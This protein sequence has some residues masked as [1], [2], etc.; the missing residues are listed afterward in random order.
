M[1]RKLTLDEVQKRVLAVN[2]NVILLTD[3]YVDNRTNMKCKCK[4]C[5]YIWFARF[6]NLT[7]K[8]SPR[9]CPQCGGTKKLTIQ[10]VEERI[11]KSNPYVELLSKSYVNSD[12]K[13]KVK[14][15][16][17]KN[18]WLASYHKLVSSDN[19]RGCP[20]CRKRKVSKAR[21][22]KK[23]EVMKRIRKISPNIEFSLEKYEGVNQKLKCQCRVCN[24]VWEASINN[25]LRGRGCPS[26]RYMNLRGEK[27]PRYN[28]NLTEE[29]RI[30]MRYRISDPETLNWR[31]NVF[32]RDNFK[33]VICSKKGGLQAHHLNGFHW[34]EDGRFDVNNGVTLC[35]YHHKDFHKKY[36]IKNNTI[37]QFQKYVEERR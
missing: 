35:V 28:P 3:T 19:P 7:R 17:C 18:I 32:E 2:P 33:C 10:E 37:E 13:L 16:E 22:L 21:K 24:N 23:E 9:G 30:K 31:K 8:D 15:Y 26:C 36:G 12:S 1:G 11:K 25:L 4:V 29:D 27:H 5:G 6:S 20:E 14:C 34:Y